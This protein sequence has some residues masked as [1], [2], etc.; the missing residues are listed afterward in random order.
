MSKIIIH[1]AAVYAANPRQPRAEALVLENNLILYVGDN[2]KALAHRDSSSQ[3]INAKGRT[4][5]P[6]IIDSHYHLG[7]GSFTLDELYLDDVKTLEQLTEAIQHYAK[8]NPHKPW[9]IGRRCSYDIEGANPL[10]RHH[11]DAIVSNKPV[12]LF[13]LDFHTVW[14]NTLALELGGILHGKDTQAGSEIVMDNGTATGELREPAAYDLVMDKRPERTES[15]KVYL[16]KQGIQLANRYGITTIHNMD[17][18]DK[19]VDRYVALEA[20]NE[21]TLRID[22]P[23]SITPAST[24]G[25][26]QQVFKW[27]KDL[28]SN[29]L[30]F[31]RIKLFMDGVIESTTALMV[32]SYA[33]INSLGDALFTA[34]HFNQLAVA[35]DKLGLQIT[36]HAIGDGAVKRTLDG[37]ESAQKNNGRRN[38]RHRIE[39][40]EVLHPSDLQRF[41]E[42]G[43]IAS[44]QPL[45]APQPHRGQYLFWMQCVGQHRY[46][47]AFP[48]QALRDAG[49]HLAFS[50]DY[51]VVTMNPFL[52]FDAAINRQSWIPELPNQAQT[53]EQT[54]NAYTNDGAYLEF[55]EQYKGQL[56]EGM[57]ADVVMLSENIFKANLET[58]KDMQAVLTIV[59]GKIV[60]D[61]SS[62][63]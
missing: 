38:S 60:Y 48:W 25:D 29:Y 17:D 56:K 37:Y 22:F 44:M 10:T 13:S 11:L 62:S 50:S 49:A 28:K 7:M 46:E 43:V 57:L 61:A 24:L 21:L 53:L 18:E 31:G 12:A 42:L 4:V 32:D 41:K 35:A 26:L 39:H 3:V 54:L 2:T 33:H 27:Q 59:D 23:L 8:N 14:V 6:G 52:G 19:R 47:W 58:I 40:I 9:I 63:T 5:M 16:I 34:E 45:H 36:V 51:P 20:S 55:A 1:N 15:E 30:R